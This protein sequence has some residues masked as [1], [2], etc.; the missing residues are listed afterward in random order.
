MGLDLRV[1]RTHNGLRCPSHSFVP[2][3]QGNNCQA[4]D[5]VVCTPLVVVTQVRILVAAP[6]VG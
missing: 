4:N 5:V 2:I 1:P 3:F 6:L